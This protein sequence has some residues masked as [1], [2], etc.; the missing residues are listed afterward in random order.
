MK[1]SEGSVGGGQDKESNDSR[2]GGGCPGGVQNLSK[3]RRI[4]S[5][6]GA[7]KTIRACRSGRS[8][9]PKRFS[10]SEGSRGESR[11]QKFGREEGGKN[12]G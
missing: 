5:V 8:S 4:E 3:R 1:G 12:T 6:A 9:Q 2:G 11:G 10:L 7:K